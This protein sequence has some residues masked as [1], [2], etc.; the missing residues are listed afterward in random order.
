[1]SSRISQI[2]LVIGVIAVIIAIVAIILIF[3]IKPPEGPQGPQGK[4]GPQG[5]AGSATSTNLVRY[6]IASF[7]ANQ[8]TLGV[9]TQNFSISTPQIINGVNE[10]SNSGPFLTYNGNGGWY[11]LNCSAV[12]EWLAGSS[13]SWQLAR[14]YKNNA[15]LY[16][17]NPTA[18]PNNGNNSTYNGSYLI[19]LNKGDILYVDWTSKFVG[20]AGI[21]STGQSYLSLQKM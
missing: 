17:M 18:D 11:T 5:P 6:N 14:V 4:Q 7:S 1:M 12:F 20:K 3:V 16:T 21:V 8:T 10:F 15:I 9:A 13:I 2:A 19:Q